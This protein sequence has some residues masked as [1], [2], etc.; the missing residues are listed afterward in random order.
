MK[1]LAIVIVAAAGIMVASHVQAKDL[2]RPKCDGAAGAEQLAKCLDDLL[3]AANER[4]NAIY[5]LI[6]Q[7]LDAGAEDPEAFFYDKKKALVAAE[8]AW[9]KFRDAQ[10]GA[11]AEMLNQASASGTVEVRGD[12]LMKMTQD[13]ITYLEQVASD[14]KSDSLLCKRTASVCQIE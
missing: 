13:R 7:M 3:G 9:I 8:R 2:T 10:C 12:C 6:M 4:L 5:G 11:E 14:I 1:H